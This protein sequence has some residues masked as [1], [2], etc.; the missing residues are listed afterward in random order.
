MSIQIVPPV[1][2]NRTFDSS[3]ARESSIADA[4]LSAVVVFC[5][6]NLS[7]GLPN[8][9]HEESASVRGNPFRETSSSP[10]VHG[11]LWVALCTVGRWQY[12]RTPQTVFPGSNPGPLLPKERRLPKQP[13]GVVAHPPSAAVGDSEFPGPI[14]A[15][16]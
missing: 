4:S 2:I 14:P 16:E 1:Y 13:Y 10:S 9:Y 3:E 6:T 5:W 12:T 15:R 7:L 11:S 8:N